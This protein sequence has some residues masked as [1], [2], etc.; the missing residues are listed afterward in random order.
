M[1]KNYPTHDLKLADTIHVL[2]TWRYYI[3]GETF[4][5]FIDH[6]ILKHMFTQKDLNMR[7]RCCIKLFKDY[8]YNILYHPGNGNVVTD[9]LNRKSADIL[10]QLMASKCRVIG[11]A[12]QIRLHDLKRVACL[13][14]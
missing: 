1:R 4:E 12:Q 7:Q 2:N 9:T 11:V 6:K 3:Y 13:A 8:D 10:A 14:T 5:I